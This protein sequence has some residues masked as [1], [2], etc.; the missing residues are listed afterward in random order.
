MKWAVENLCEMV[1]ASS[2]IKQVT[3]QA[4]SVVSFPQGML[5][6]VCKTLPHI[7][8]NYR[9][10]TPSEKSSHRLIFIK[11]VWI[12]R[13]SSQLGYQ[14]NLN[15]FQ[16]PPFCFPSSYPFTKHLCWG[17]RRH[18]CTNPCSQGD[19]T[20]TSSERQS[21]WVS[22]VC[23]I[24]IGLIHKFGSWLEFQRQAVS[25]Q[26]ALGTLLWIR[27]NFLIKMGETWRQDAWLPIVPFQLYISFTLTKIKGNKEVKKAQSQKLWS[28]WKLKQMQAF[29]FLS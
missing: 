9:C 19:N 25:T 22:E 23:F 2:N 27:L 14:P 10:S 20:I 5:N 26:E 4:S 8:R 11:W 15:S 3:Q 29:Q 21:W 16:W 28:Y 24:N 13:N 6:W 1:P 18:V 17:A 12:N 7:D